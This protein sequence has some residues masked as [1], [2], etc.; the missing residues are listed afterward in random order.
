MKKQNHFWDILGICIGC[1]Q[2]MGHNEDKE[3][4]FNYSEL[5]PL[6]DTKDEPKYPYPYTGGMNTKDE[7]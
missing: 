2:T 6:N 4:S 3:C 5:K 1:G 7:E